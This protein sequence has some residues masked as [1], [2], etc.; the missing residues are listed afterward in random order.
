MIHKIDGK[1][2]AVG[3]LD[4]TPEAMSSVYLFYDPEYEFISPG[5]LCALREIEYIQNIVEKHDTT[6][7]YY[8][9]GLYFQDCQKSVYKANYKPS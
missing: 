4:L 1:T 7:K 9:L 2:F 3:V 6:F 8:Y 5:T